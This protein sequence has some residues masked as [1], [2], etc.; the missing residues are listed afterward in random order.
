[1]QGRPLVAA[2]VVLHSKAITPASPLRKVVNFDQT[3][4]LLAAYFV[5]MA[6]P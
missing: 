3:T 4:V 2:V 5:I 6:T 1:M